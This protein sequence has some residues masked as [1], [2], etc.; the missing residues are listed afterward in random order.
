MSAKRKST[1]PT[2]ELATPPIVLN[3]TNGPR[4]IPYGAAS[5]ADTP[6]IVDLERMKFASGLNAPK[7]PEQWAIVSE[8]H[9]YKTWVDQGVLEELQL[10]SEVPTVGGADEKIIEASSSRPSM[11]WWLKH[12]TRP[13]VKTKL[14][15]KIAEMK[16]HRM[17]GDED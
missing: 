16:R 12:E 11:E 14:R 15:K 7:D 10:V 2:A 8:L 9:S 17:P 6:G 3:N 1:E 13:G 4:Y 5:D